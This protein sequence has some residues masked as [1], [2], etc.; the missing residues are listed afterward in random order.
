M[1]NDVDAPIV[2]Y[3]LAGCTCDELVWSIDTPSAHMATCPVT[4]VR[5]LG[6]YVV[7]RAGKPKRE[8]GPGV[9]W[10]CTCPDAASIAPK[11]CAHLKAL[12]VGHVDEIAQFT[13]ALDVLAKRRTRKGTFIAKLTELGADILRADWTIRALRTPKS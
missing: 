10:S 5:D 11:P 6:W 3:I 2:A 9:S 1:S 8:K 13:D 4:N 7:R 12:F